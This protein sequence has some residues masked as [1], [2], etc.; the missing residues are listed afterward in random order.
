LGIVLD[1][2]DTTVETVLDAL[3]TTLDM[4]LDTAQVTSLT[5]YFIF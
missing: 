3:E 5:V 1:A 4:V 2:L